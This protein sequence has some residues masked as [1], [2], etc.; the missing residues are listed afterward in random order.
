MCD[1][2]IVLSFQKK[3]TKP[4]TEDQHIDDE[5]DRLVSECECPHK[6]EVTKV[7]ERKYRVSSLR[8]MS[9]VDVR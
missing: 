8:F 2:Y 7:A 4:M 3:S 9:L 6:F 5:I 1:I